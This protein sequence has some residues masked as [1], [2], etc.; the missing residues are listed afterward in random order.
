MLV[1]CL[2]LGMG[3]FLHVV[4]KE[5]HRRERW[6]TLRLEEKIKELKQRQVNQEE[7]AKPLG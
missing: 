5:K 4:A 1:I 3:I 7:E 2:V 6:L